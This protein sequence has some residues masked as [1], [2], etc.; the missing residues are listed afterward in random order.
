MTGERFVRPRRA[1]MIWL[2]LF[3]GVVLALTWAHDAIIGLLGG[4]LVAGFA[5]HWSWFALVVDDDGLHADSVTGKRRLSIAWGDIRSLEIQ[6]SAIVALTV[7]GRHSQIRQIMLAEFGEPAQILAAIRAH[8][9]PQLAVSPPLPPVPEIGIRPLLIMALAIPLLLVIMNAEQAQLVAWHAGAEPRV[10]L[11]VLVLPLA[12]VL[13]WLGVRGTGMH[14]PW[15]TALVVGLVLAP[16][17]TFGLLTGNRWHTEQRPLSVGT[18]L[19]RLDR[20]DMNGQHWRAVVPDADF[21]ERPLR[22]NGGWSGYESG[23]QAGAVYRVGVWRGWLG[24]V[25]IRPGTFAVET[26]EEGR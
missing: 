9:G 17:L 25:A 18:V 20:S 2:L 4:L 26:S 1:I 13:A 12:V 22:I 21:G 5:M 19:L 11:F 3:G 16:V 8:G 23:L 15:R 14:R 6:Y 7:H 10:L 24:D